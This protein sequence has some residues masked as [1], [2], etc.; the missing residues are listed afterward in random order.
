MN[1]IRDLRSL[2]LEDPTDI[3]KTQF[4]SG[5]TPDA[6]GSTTHG[7]R[8]HGTGDVGSFFNVRVPDETAQR[9]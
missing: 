5:G 3:S 8:Y 2:V 9:P 6:A 4:S 7:W 1:H